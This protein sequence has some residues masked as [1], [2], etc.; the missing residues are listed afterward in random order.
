MLLERQNIKHNIKP[1]YSIRQLERPLNKLQRL[2]K[3]S[4]QLASCKQF[5]SSMGSKWYKCRR[6]EITD[7]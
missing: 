2:H 4:M 1:L 7:K 5:M 6:L 3:N